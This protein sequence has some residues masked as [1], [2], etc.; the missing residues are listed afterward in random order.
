MRYLTS[1]NG[2]L[3]QTC[4]QQ[5]S[6]RMSLNFA[7]ANPAVIVAIIF[8]NKSCIQ[9]DRQT[10]MAAGKAQRQIFKTNLER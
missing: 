4:W 10:E 3:V 1:G 6:M 7:N 5:V 9:H 8:D 2:V